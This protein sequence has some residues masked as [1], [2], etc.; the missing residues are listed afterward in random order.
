M[1][2]RSD[3]VSPVVAEEDIHAYV[4]G[5][6][7][8]TRRSRVEAYLA[9]HPQEAARVETYRA[10]N[11]GL[12][13]L[14]DSVP[15]TSLP[16]PMA[17]MAKRLQHAIRRQKRHRSM[18]L[19]AASVCAVAVTGAVAWGT[20]GPEIFGG[21]EIQV[22]SAPDT[23][24]SEGDEPGF[25]P[26][27]DRI[28]GGHDAATLGL[29]SEHYAGAPMQAPDL[30]QLGFKLMVQRVFPTASGPGAQLLYQNQAGDWIALYIGGDQRSGQ[31]KFSYVKREGVSMFYWRRGALAYGLSGGLQ[32]EELNK[33]AKNVSDQLNVANLQGAAREGDTASPALESLPQ[34][35][36]EQQS[37]EQVAEP[38]RVTPVVEDTSSVAPEPEDRKRES[39]PSTSTVEEPKKPEDT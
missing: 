35:T 12:H 32:R 21:K 26:P 29:L 18:A 9:A 27:I 31:T 36:V 37:E 8:G 38:P 25:Y 28:S 7:D 30:E 3:N 4:D 15:N 5:I 23:V 14:Y 1:R 2:G 13:V 6:L 34:L 22:A 17:D 20:V 19:L 11:I 33:I 16:A 24:Q 39:E 10:Q